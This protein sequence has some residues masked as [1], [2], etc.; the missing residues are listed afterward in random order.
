[1][2][3]IYLA[4]PTNVLSG[5]VFLPYSIGTIAAYSFEK[6]NIRENYKLCEL[7]FLKEDIETIVSRAESPYLIG[8]SCYLWNIEYNLALAKRIKEVY[9][10]CITIFGG[11]QIPDD[12]TYLEKYPF[13]DI[14]IHCEGEIPFYEILES[15]AGKKNINEICNI[16][17]RDKNEIIKTPCNFERDISDFPSPYLNGYFDSIINN[18]DYSHIQ[19]DVLIET[20]RG[21]PYTCLYC[22]WGHKSRK[23]RLFPMEKV[24]AELKW[25]AQHKLPYCFCTDANF[26][27]LPRDKETVDYIVSL[28]KETGFPKVF[29]TMAAKNKDDFV[30]ELNVELHKAGL[31]KGVSI[32]CQSRSETVLRNINRE[33]I[34]YK[35]L[36]GI[37]TRYWDAGIPSYTDMIIGLPGETYESF[38]K[39]IFEI[40]E[41]GQKFIN[42]FPCELLPNSE[43]YTDEIRN[44]YSIKSK[45]SFVC[46]NHGKAHQKD[47]LQD[48]YSEIVIATDTMP[49]ED[50]K[51]TYLLSVCAQT[52]HG[53]GLLYYI[54]MYFYYTQNISLYDFYV[55]YFEWFLSNDTVAGS[56]LKYTTKSLDEFLYKD[57]DIGFF[58]ERFGDIYW[59]FEEAFFLCLTS[60]KNIFFNELKAYLE[61]TYEIKKE[62]LCDLIDFQRL[63]V[64]SFIPSEEKAEFRYDW[65]DFFESKGEK[66]LI[67]GNTAYCFIREQYEDIRDYAKN[68]V[69]FG[70]R[71]NK[72]VLK[73]QYET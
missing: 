39:G 11:P 60:D 2:K 54:S 25:A 37:L 45:K 27:I 23:V 16:S 18:P 19:F 38:G 63:S 73:T 56:T 8:F 59:P 7:I 30:Y 24:K 29:E 57:G 35:D 10:D 9:P 22:A 62:V 6:E 61:S 28:R 3:N 14:L 1:M 70:K 36:K 58:D 17:Y 5:G 67:S 55:N 4:Q 31:S 21:C 44:K 65:K 47:H 72:T 15:L 49:Q 71:L 40:L 20:N 26:G 48:L 52:F 42:I 46:K 33:N 68:V 51:K 34:A 13:T 32:A 12:T 64:N 50:W 43:L 69:W 53:L 66:P 41:C